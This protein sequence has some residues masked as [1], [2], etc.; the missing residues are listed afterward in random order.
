MPRTNVE[1]LTEMME[2]SN[3]GALAQCFIIDAVSKHAKAVIDHEAEL[4]EQMKD[5]MVYGPSWVGV[6]KEIHAKMEAHFHPTG[7]TSDRTRT[8]N[9]PAGC[10][11]GQKAERLLAKA[12]DLQSE[13][14]D[15]L[16]Q[17]EDEL[18]VEIDS[19]LDLSNHT[20]ESLAD[21]K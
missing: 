11:D 16:R 2:H 17:L 19:T 3:F 6:A 20:T 9:T 12:Q 7:E 1:A 15:A 18:D 8:G 10:D 13:L 14:W 4:L 21:L 5:S